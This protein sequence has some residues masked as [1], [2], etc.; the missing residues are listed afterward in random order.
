MWP[1]IWSSLATCPTPCCLLSFPDGFVIWKMNNGLKTGGM[2][3]TEEGG[4][5]AE[6]RTEHHF[7][8]NWQF[9]LPIWEPIIPPQ[10]SDSF[11]DPWGAHRLRHCAYSTCRIKELKG[12]DIPV[13]WPAL[14]FYSPCLS[15]HFPPLPPRILSVS[16]DCTARGPGVIQ[17]CWKWQRR[18]LWVILSVLLQVHLKTG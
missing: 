15:P 8:K 18:K 4:R 2:S 14:S 6:I 1:F 12:S 17:T 7:F 10:V 3:I 13:L 5:G 11:L 9:S 16:F